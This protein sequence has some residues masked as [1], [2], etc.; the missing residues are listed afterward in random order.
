MLAKGIVHGTT[1][2]PSRADIANW[3]NAAMAEMK[4]EGRI[5]QN[6]WRRHGYEGFVV[7]DKEVG[8]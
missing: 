8:D 7:G 4:V 6:A 1:S 2:P 3:V 5:I